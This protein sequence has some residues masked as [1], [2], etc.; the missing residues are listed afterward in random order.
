MNYLIVSDS[1]E[2]QKAKEKE[3]DSY[4]DHAAV[5]IA[6]SKYGVDLSRVMGMR[7]ILTWKPQMDEAGNQVG[8]RAK[9]HIITKEFQDPDLLRIQRDR[10]PLS[11]L[12]RNLLFSLISLQGWKLW[13]GDIKTAFLNGDDTKL[14]RSI[15][16]DPPGDVKQY[17]GTSEQQLFR[18][19]KAI[20]GLLNAP[21][22]WFN[23]IT[24]ELGESGWIRSKLESVGVD[25]SCIRNPNSR[26][27]YR[28]H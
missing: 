25:C 23:K 13:L 15:Y 9:A 8:N 27:L 1:S 16:G 20:Y 21:R 4:I 7:W 17:L 19:R 3:I 2:F 28:Y 18:V 11:T 14:E 24:K 10:P 22:K 12:G 6:S 26:H 5:D